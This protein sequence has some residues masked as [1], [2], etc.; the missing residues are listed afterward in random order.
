MRSKNLLEHIL[1]HHRGLFAT[2]FLLPISAVYGAIESIRQR[3][4]FLLKS[5]PAKHGQRVA[6]VV[7]Q[8]EDWQRAGC[9]EKLCTARSGWKTMSE[10]VPKYK[11][12][13]RNIDVGL[14]DILHIDKQRRSI[15]VEPLASMG[16]ITQTLLPLGWTLPVVPELDDLTVGGLI[17]GFGVESSSHKYGLF[18]SI[19]ESFDIVTAEGRML[20]CTAS[21]NADLYYS[22]PWSH[23][24]LGFLVAAELRIIPAKKYVKLHYQP[25]HSLEETVAVFEAA[26]RDTE[27]TDFVEGLVY[28]REGAVVMRGVL[29]DD[30]Q[31]DGKYNP[32]GRWYQPWFYKQVEKYLQ[33]RK[34]G[35]EYIP[36]R[37]YYHRHTRS[38]FWMMEEVI[39]FGNHP[40][41]RWLLGWAVPPKIPLLK[42]T[43]TETTR[44]LR[45]KHQVL[46]DMLMPMAKLK[47]SIDYFAD[48]YQLYPLW[49]SP[50]AV[51]GNERGQGFLHPYRDAD[52][53]EDP[54][55]VDIGAYGTPHKPGLDN[56]EALPLLERFVVDNQGYQ[57]LYAKTMLSREDF[58]RMFDHRDYDRVR[59]ALPFCTLA[60]D[61]VYD[62]VSAKG[63]VAPV[64]ARRL[65]KASLPP[66][67]NPSPTRGEGL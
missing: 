26:C 67:P 33:E 35:I 54:M 39:P 13:H 66:H 36:L 8:I 52:G 38:L 51:Y 29:T 59:E 25:T 31:A 58:R 61:E 18:Q 64:E 6:R 1:T 32:I 11:L 48:H 42:Y 41:F 14:Y 7:R 62:K 16:Q 34:E 57:A 47:E 21:E 9:K 3:A 19:C 50:M 28:S 49:L 27:H 22:I 46:Q 44:E 40:V 10:L 20:H 37:H 63:R 12:S 65:K 53:K 17:M 5:A 45:E 4:V 24:T 60:F 43:E 15:K 56:R 55:Y 2:V 23:G 30:I